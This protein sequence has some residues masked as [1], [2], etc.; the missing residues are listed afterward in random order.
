MGFLFSIFGANNMRK[1]LG[2]KSP[3]HDWTKEYYFKGLDDNG[4]RM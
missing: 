1:I 2:G 3:V 4:D